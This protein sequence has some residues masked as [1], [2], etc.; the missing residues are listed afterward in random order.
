MLSN[1][2]KTTAKILSILTTLNNYAMLF[3]RSDE[4]NFLCNVDEKK[5]IIIRRDLL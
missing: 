2:G 5:N 4:V 1:Q 3:E